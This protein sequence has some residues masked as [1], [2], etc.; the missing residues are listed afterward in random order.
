VISATQYERYQDWM[1]CIIKFKGTFFL[2]EIETELAKKNKQNITNEVKQFIYGGY[3]FESYVTTDDRESIITNDTIEKT[4]DNSDQYFS[5]INAELNKNRLL[6]GAEV[7]C[8]FNSQ[9]NSL[10]DYC[11]LK[12]SAGDSLETLQ[13]DKN[14]KF[15]KWW[16]QSSFTGIN[17]IMI[18]LRNDD[19]IVKKIVECPLDHILKSKKKVIFF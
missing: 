9:H 5:M 13:F 15:L 16:L 14:Y 10:K 11:E 19:N 17:K 6:Y 4:P 12:T 3:K 18:G 2:C 1:I 7:D 8:C